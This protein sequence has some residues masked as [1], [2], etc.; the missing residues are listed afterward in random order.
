MP[1]WSIPTGDG[2][3]K[4]NLMIATN[5]L[6]DL[7]T[8]DQNDP[9]VQKLISQGLV[10]SYDELIEQYAPELKNEIPTDVW[11]YSKAIPGMWKMGAKNIRALV[12]M[13]ID[14]LFRLNGK[15]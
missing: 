15:E 5:A 6:P 10:Y 12:G 2:T 3:E 4:V 1:E 9:S 11:N 7:V 14:F 13:N 8:M